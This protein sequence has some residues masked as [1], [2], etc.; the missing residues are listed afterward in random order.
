MTTGIDDLAL[1]LFASPKSVFRLAHYLEIEELKALAL[2]SIRTQLT[3]EN[4]AVELVSDVSRCYQDV[5]KVVLDF[6]VD[7]WGKV[8]ASKAMVELERQIEAEEVAV[9]TQV[10]GIF[11]K[12]A[13]GL[14]RA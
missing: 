8:K 10:L 6:V 2:D 4:A 11:V 7:N 1:P 13:K 12:L 14:K 5:Q 9:P 3:V